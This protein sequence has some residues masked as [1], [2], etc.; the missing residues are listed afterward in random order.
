MLAV[1][2]ANVSCPCPQRAAHSPDSLRQQVAISLPL[3]CMLGHTN[4]GRWHVYH[5][6]IHECCQWE[7]STAYLQHWEFVCR[8]DHQKQ[9][10]EAV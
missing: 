1:Q 6:H 9:E 8:D 3:H 2:H 5:T 7:M 4:L 10:T